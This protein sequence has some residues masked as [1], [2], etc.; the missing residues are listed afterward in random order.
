MATLQDSNQTLASP[1]TL[2]D[3][4]LV[5]CVRRRVFY[6][7]FQQLIKLKQDQDGGEE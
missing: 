5:Q 2:I 3:N 7:L 6:G 4:E 1:A